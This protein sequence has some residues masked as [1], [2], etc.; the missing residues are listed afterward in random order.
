MKQ[1][2]EFQLA[3]IDKIAEVA[4]KRQRR[5][6][7]SDSKWQKMEAEQNAA[8]VMNKT[9]EA[10]APFVPDRNPIPFLRAEDVEYFEEDGVTYAMAT[11]SF[12]LYVL[13]ELSK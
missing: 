5:Y 11:E 7:I 1:Y 13:S 6:W 2:S 10:R 4:Q 8:Y 12:L 9:V 3:L